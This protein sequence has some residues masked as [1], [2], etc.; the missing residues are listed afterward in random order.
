MKKTNLPLVIKNIKTIGIKHGPGVLTGMGLVGM[1]SAMVSVARVTP[2]ALVLLD[3]KKEQLK[4]DQLE[5]EDAVK[6][7]WK[8]YLP[9]AVT[10]GLSAACIIGAHTINTRRNAALMA[11]YTLSE[12][13]LKDYQEKVVETIGEKKEQKIK[14]AVVKDKIE[15][16]PVSNTEVIV[17]EKGNTLCYDVISG[18][19][20]KSDIEQIKKAINE[21]NRRMMTEMYISLNEFYYE[22]GLR[23]TSIGNELGWNINGDGLIEIHFGSQLADNGDPCVV[24]DY[25]VAP[26]Y[27]YRGLM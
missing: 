13:A 19:Y 26:R 2:R 7:T 20:F 8:C 9:A 1:C 23:P 6:T 11:A 15:K 5:L 27:D 16:N 18:R 3:E 4:T 25:H 12:T 14:E 22:L 10:F 17:T 21:L 24:V